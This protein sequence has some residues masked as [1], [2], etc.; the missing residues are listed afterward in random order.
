MQVTL[1]TLL[2]FDTIKEAKSFF[3]YE[4]V[5]VADDC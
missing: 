4:A 5:Q 2:S 3:S 1:E